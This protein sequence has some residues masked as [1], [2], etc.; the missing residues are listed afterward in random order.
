MQKQQ[1]LAPCRNRQKTQ[2]YM[3]AEICKYDTE[4]LSVCYYLS[5]FLLAAFFIPVFHLCASC[6][7]G[8]HT[9]RATRRGM[10]PGEH[11]VL[12]AHYKYNK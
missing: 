7:L 2:C 12:Y 9:C 1:L 8:K 6:A 5:I 11:Q 10:S 4:G 3:G